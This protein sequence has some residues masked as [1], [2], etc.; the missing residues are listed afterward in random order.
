MENEDAKP[1]LLCFGGSFNPIHYGH[2]RCL[3][4]LADSRPGE[5]ILIIPTAQPPHKQ[6]QADI[7]GATDR[8]ALCRIAVA[9]EP[10]FEVSDLEVRRS[11]PSYTIDT[12][13]EL[14]RQGHS[15]ISWLIGADMLL[16]L[17]KWHRSRELLEQVTFLVMPRPSV[18]I[19]WA[20]LPPAYRT[21]QGNLLDT[22]LVDISATEIRRRVK[23]GESIDTLTP[24]AV[25]Q[26]IRDHGLYR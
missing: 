21:L 13:A 22:P 3:R 25:A 8:L 19:D 24:P 14:R 26:Y 15:H 17:P 4:Y 5:T 11:G 20:A 2:L 10:R 1:R 9:D 16:Y 6:R 18:P 7:A 23:A 12:V